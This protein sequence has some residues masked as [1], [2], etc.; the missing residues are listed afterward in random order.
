MSKRKKKHRLIALVPRMG[1]PT[2]LR[3]AGAHR[4]ERRVA[5]LEL[6]KFEAE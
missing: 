3:P 1:P 4:D 2:N 6:R 5:K